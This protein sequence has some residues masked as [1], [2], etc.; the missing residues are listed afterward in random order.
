MTSIRFH[1]AD[2][3]VVLTTQLAAYAA[4]ALGIVGVSYEAFTYWHFAS[5]TACSLSTRDSA[6]L[7]CITPPLPVPSPDLKGGGYIAQYNHFTLFML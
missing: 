6:I 2:R 7:Q 1:M 5:P 4:R 3:M